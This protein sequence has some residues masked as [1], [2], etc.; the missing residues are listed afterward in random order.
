MVLVHHFGGQ[1]RAQSHN[2]F[3]L[4]LCTALTHNP[5]FYGVCLKFN[6]TYVFAYVL[7]SLV[8]V[9]HIFKHVL[10]NNQLY[11]LLILHNSN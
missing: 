11:Q 1:L 7:T 10:I 6:K 3:N 2:N 4:I 9:R 8:A 5:F